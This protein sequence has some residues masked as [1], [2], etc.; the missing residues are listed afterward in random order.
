[1]SLL[2]I[3]SG[4]FQ[5]NFPAYP[6]LIRHALTGHPMFALE[7][8]L[9]L[10][11]ALPAEEIEYNAGDLAVNQDA[12][13]TPR[14]GLSVADTIQRIRECKSWMV[15]KH[16]E[17]DTE[18]RRLLFDCLEEVR[19]AGGLAEQGVLQREGFVFLSSPGSVTPFHMDPEH[20]FLLQIQGTKTVYMWDPEDRSVLPETAIERFYGSGTHRNMPFQQ[21]W[22]AK[23][24]RF[25]LHPGDAVYFPPTAP[26]WVQNGD[27]VSVSFSITFRS[28]A[29]DRRQRVYWVNH[30]LRSMGLTPKPFG[31]VGLIDSAKNLA[32][33]TAGKARRALKPGN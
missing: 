3:E 17:L 21:E 32:V 27:D 31:R 11:R 18:Y 26:H 1:M 29:G 30:R 4:V 6:F 28:E 10:G 16:V 19:H 15:M 12:K 22:Q 23:A 9:E 25:D 7:R 13:L 20:N 33:Q 2:N 24:L 8:L 14:N 5:K